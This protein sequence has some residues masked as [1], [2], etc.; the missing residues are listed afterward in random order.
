MLPVRCSHYSSVVAEEIGIPV[1]L[2]LR[3]IET[4]LT[5]PDHSPVNV[6]LE[7]VRNAVKLTTLVYHIFSILCELRVT[8][9]SELGF[10]LVF[11]VHRAL[12]TKLFIEP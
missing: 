6:I 4:K 2:D 10:E 8:V 1:E 7:E 5:I 3:V 12:N 11:E 9:A